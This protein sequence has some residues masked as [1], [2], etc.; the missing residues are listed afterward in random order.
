MRSNLLIQ[1]FL[2]RGLT[3]FPH[4]ALYND[5]WV[6][7]FYTWGIQN[8]REIYEFKMPKKQLMVFFRS[9]S[10]L[11]STFRVIS[12]VFIFYKFNI[13]LY[14]VVGAFIKYMRKCHSDVLLFLQLCA[15]L[16]PEGPVPVLLHW[17]PG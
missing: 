10:T 11:E 2:W 8:M 12:V 16:G 1:Y 4:M 5:A 17:G 6:I 3:G 9:F 7:Y 15:L 14:N 13:I